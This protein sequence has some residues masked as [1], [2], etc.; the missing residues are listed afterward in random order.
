LATVASNYI[1]TT[2]TANAHKTSGSSL[3]PGIQNTM[4]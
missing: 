2:K 4:E 3:N 1:I